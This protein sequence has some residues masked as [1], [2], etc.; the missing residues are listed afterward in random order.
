MGKVL[1]LSDEGCELIGHIPENFSEYQKG[2]VIELINDT[3]FLITYN[4][5]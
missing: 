2:G 1:G 5:P 4:S 3:P